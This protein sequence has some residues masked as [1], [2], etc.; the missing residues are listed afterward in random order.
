MEYEWRGH[1]VSY[2]SDLLK[3]QAN[4]GTCG[5]WQE[6]DYYVQV[7]TSACQYSPVYPS[8]SLSACLS[9]LF[10]ALPDVIKQSITT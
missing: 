5:L 9:R 6:F 4:A 2:V 3:T 8:V 7:R 10:K 1:K